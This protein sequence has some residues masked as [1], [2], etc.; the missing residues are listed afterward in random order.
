MGRMSVLFAMTPFL[1][2]T[3]AGGCE[4]VLAQGWQRVRGQVEFFQGDR[5]LTH[6]AAEEV[7]SV[8]RE[9]SGAFTPAPHAGPHTS[10]GGERIG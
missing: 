5:I 4:R 2:R 3:V 7:I 6:Y 10:P 8:R 1:V 9:V